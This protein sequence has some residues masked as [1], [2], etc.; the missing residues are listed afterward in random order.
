[1]NK[2]Y[3]LFFL[4][5]ILGCGSEQTDDVEASEPQAYFNPPAEGFDFAGSD[6]EAITIADSV[7][8]AHGGRSAWE[9][10][11][12]FS[13][14]FFGL[15]DLVWDRYLGRVRITSEKDATVYVYN[16][17]T[18]E[19]AIQV[20][21]TLITDSVEVASASSRAKSIM[22]NDTYW[23]VFPFKLKDSGT[24]LSYQGEVDA[25]PQANRPSF[26]I[27][28]TFTDVGDTPQN[29]YRIYVDRETYLMNTW[30]FYRQADDEE[31]MIE[32]PFNN[33]RE[34]GGL[35]MSDDRGSR[36][37]LGE[38]SVLDDV[39]ESTFSLTNPD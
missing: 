8:A 13:F 18:G 29:R 22:I 7:M 37:Q 11:R 31:A 19:G 25:D 38:V 27:D 16:D 17:E 9:K 3:Q 35:L 36:F 14:N 4:M 32:T 12:Y 10:A 15:R 23:L 6:S 21:G 20:N 1:M 24:T 33:Y 30:Q 34:I 28:L 2:I 5:L 39:D 26:V